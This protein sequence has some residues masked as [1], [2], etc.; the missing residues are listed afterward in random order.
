MG[1]KPDG[2]DDLLPGLEQPLWKGADEEF[3]AYVREA[4][5]IPVT[6]TTITITP[7]G[8]AGRSAVA[9]GGHAG[10]IIFALT[11][12]GH[13]THIAPIRAALRRR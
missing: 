10:A 9:I 1:D 7:R 13:R 5:G 6:I 2:I 8:R 3:T 11:P 4:F 12:G